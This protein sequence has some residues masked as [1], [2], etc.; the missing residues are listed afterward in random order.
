MSLFKNCMIYLAINI[1]SN[2][3]HPPY[4]PINI[5]LTWNLNKL[6]KRQ[7]KLFTINDWSYVSEEVYDRK[8]GFL[9][10]NYNG[11]IEILNKGVI[12]RAN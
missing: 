9:L 6:E 4:S 7:M 12:I 2:K 5:V 3:L 8:T 1:K 11:R 10:L